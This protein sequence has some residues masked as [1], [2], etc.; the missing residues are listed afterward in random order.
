MTDN[1][2]RA[3]EVVNL[4][5]HRRQSHQSIIRDVSTSGFY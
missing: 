3:Q 2:I 4:Y 1:S 5:R